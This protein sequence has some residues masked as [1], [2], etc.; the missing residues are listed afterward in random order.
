MDGPNQLFVDLTR[1][2]C[3]HWLVLLYRMLHIWEVVSCIESN[4][5]VRSKCTSE[6]SLYEI[7]FWRGFQRCTGRLVHDI[8][9]GGNQLSSLLG[10][11]RRGFAKE[12]IDCNAKNRV[13]AV[14]SPICSRY[15]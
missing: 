14:Y 3:M 10:T 4:M 5:L 12:E 6:N 15:G 7:M 13:D 2:S 11:E 9:L 8:L 1:P